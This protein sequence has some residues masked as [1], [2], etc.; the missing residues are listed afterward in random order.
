MKDFDPFC[1]YVCEGTLEILNVFLEQ[2][3]LKLNYVLQG[4]SEGYTWIS[5][6]CPFRVA[7]YNG[8]FDIVKR[9]LS[10]QFLKE[11][12]DNMSN[13]CVFFFL[14]S[15]SLI[16]INLVRIMI[17]TIIVQLVILMVLRNV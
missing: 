15:F 5:K 6:F 10:F 13:V 1:T 17:F 7:I 4:K 8:S 9:L 2:K 3:N 11:Y 12:F 14:N 16:F